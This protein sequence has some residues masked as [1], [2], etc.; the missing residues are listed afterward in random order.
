MRPDANANAHRSKTICRP[1]HKGGRH[2][3]R[4]KNETSPSPPHIVWFEVGSANSFCGCCLLVSSVL[5]MEILPDI[6]CILFPFNRL[7]R[8]SLVQAKGI[9]NRPDHSLQ[10]WRQKEG[11]IDQTILA[12]LKENCS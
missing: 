9:L 7:F 12:R 11:L 2:K 5:K 8:N 6:T 1:P 4:G 10:D 3:N